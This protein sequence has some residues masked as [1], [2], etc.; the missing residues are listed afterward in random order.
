MNAAQADRRVK[1]LNLQ[2]D[3]LPEMPTL[4]DSN[5]EMHRRYGIH[6]IPVLFV[7]DRDSVVRRQFIGTQNESE[8]REAIR[9]VVDR[10]AP[11]Q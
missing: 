9:S 10:K 7:I 11:N 4:L 1:L 6:K 8:L 2:S 5:R 3:P